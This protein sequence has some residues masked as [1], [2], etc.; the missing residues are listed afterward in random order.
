MKIYNLGS[1]NID[2]IYRLPH[3]VS[4]GETISARSY[5]IGLGGKGANQSIAAARAGGAVCHIGALNQT[6]THWKDQIAEKGVNVDHIAALE[7]PTGHAIVMVD[8]NSGENQIVIYPGCNEQISEHQIDAALAQA[9]EG[10]WVLTQNETN[11]SDYLFKKAGEKGLK[12]CYSAAPFDAEQ[13]KALLPL[14]DLLVVNEGEAAALEKALGRP[15]E[16][17]AVEHLVIT[18][19]A[20]GARYLGSQGEFQLPAPR[21]DAVDTTGAG[22]TFL[23]FLL[24]GLCQHRSICDAMTLALAAASL[25]VTHAGAADAIPTE[26]AVREWLELR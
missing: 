23:G 14:T 11:G 26:Q 10:D 19:G 15:P 17:W 13:V 6:E 16:A 3:L 4:A 9:G 25:Q 21:V 24:T 22:D 12:R 18:L 1:I 20:Q 2:H 8:Q 5:Q 7:A